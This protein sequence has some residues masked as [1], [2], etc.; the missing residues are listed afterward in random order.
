MTAKEMLAAWKVASTKKFYEEFEKLT[1]F[2]KTEVEK[3]FGD[4]N[5]LSHETAEQIAYDC[6]VTLHEGGFQGYLA[7]LT[8]RPPIVDDGPESE[9][10]SGR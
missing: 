8:S 2:S 1:G 5:K 4:W 10:S 9:P 6:G 7:T 3:H